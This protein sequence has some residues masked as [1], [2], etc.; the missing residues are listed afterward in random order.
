MITAEKNRC[1]DQPYDEDN[2]AMSFF[3]RNRRDLAKR[4]IDPDRLP[5]GQYNTDRFPVLHVGDVPTYDMRTWTLQIFGNVERPITL[6]WDELRDLP[7]VEITTDIHCVTKWS[8]FDTV[9]KGVRLRDLYALAGMKPDTLH[10]IEHAEHG[11]T[12]NVPIADTLGDN[13]LLTYAYGGKPL[14][15][16]HGYP[17]RTLIPHLY[18]WK[19]A[20]W[21]RGLELSTKDKPGFWEV[22]GYHNYGDPFREQRFTHD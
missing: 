8:K 14:E 22:R 11:Y 20:K 5:S 1:N 12:T 13:C 3:E 17:A 10:L 19:S 2:D 21:I 16:E 6:S 9:W 15:A 4:G 18:F 7:S